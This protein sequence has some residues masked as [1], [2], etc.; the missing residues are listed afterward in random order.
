MSADLSH[1]DRA[2]PAAGAAP[3]LATAA[4]PLLVVIVNY[5][6]A[7]LTIT[8]LE[9]LRPELATYPGAQV[10]VVDNASGDGPALGQAI[11]A[12]NWGDW[13]RLT[14]LDRNAGFAAGNN[15]AIRPALATNRPPRLILLLNADTEVRPGAIRTLVEFMDRN[16]TV[17]IA[18]SSFE[19]VDGTDWDLAFRFFTP[20][21]EL[22]RGLRFGPLTRLLRRHLVN[23]NMPQDYAQPTDWVAGACMMIRREVFDA[24]GLMDEDYFLYYEEVDFCLQAH[25]QGWPCWYVPQSRIMHIGG[26]STGMTER[27]QRPPRTPTYWFDARRHY[28]RKNFGWG[29][30]IAANLAYGLGFAGWR[31]RRWICRLPD[32]DPPHHLGDFWRYSFIP[33]KHPPQ[34]AGG[35]HP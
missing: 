22:E 31:L 9:T 27:Y 6:T 29:G 8:C 34:T 15:G 2:D 7:A 35:G 16:P 23:R 5:K 26:Q 28:F 18:G 30:L 13:V 33:N 3:A 12:R 1:L 10:A 20:L 32:M 4:C 17:G 24:V 19:N 11:A 25:R 21:N 14:V